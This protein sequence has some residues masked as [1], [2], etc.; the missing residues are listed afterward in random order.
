MDTILT[1]S[2]E[3]IRIRSQIAK[4]LLSQRTTSVSAKEQRL[5]VDAAFHT[6]N[7]IEHIA[8]DAINNEFHGLFLIQSLET[9]QHL[10]DRHCSTLKD[11][12]HNLPTKANITTLIQQLEELNNTSR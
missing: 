7:A 3:I 4:A 1:I 8:Q 9:A 11:S 10:L 5:I 6:S 12:K 2:F